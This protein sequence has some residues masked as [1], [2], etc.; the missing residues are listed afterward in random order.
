MTGPSN[1][2]LSGIYFPPHIIIHKLLSKT[3]D[4]NE[5]ERGPIGGGGDLGENEIGSA[6]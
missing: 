5:N 1:Y 2:D 4:V 3:N 6:G